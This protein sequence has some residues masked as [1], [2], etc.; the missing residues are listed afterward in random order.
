MSPTDRAD[1]AACVH[2]KQLISNDFLYY[3]YIAPGGAHIEIYV[4][5]GCL[6]LFR[7]MLAMC[8]FNPM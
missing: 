7:A 4:H 2:C 8:G 3:R 5:P 6:N 1:K